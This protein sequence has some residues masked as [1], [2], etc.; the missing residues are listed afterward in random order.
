MG[1]EAS[2]QERKQALN[3]CGKYRADEGKPADTSIVKV[4]EGGENETFEQAFEVGVM[5]KYDPSKKGKYGNVAGRIKGLSRTKAAA[6]ESTETSGGPKESTLGGP[7][8]SP[9]HYHIIQTML[10]ISRNS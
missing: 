1:L 9:R 3:Y 6:R 10:R 4:L 8:E 5:S 7:Q 2:I